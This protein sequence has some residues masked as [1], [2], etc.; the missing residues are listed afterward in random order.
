M[1]WLLALLLPLCLA[2]D[3]TAQLVKN[4]CC[5]VRGW[6]DAGES[7]VWHTTI[8]DSARYNKQS[9]VIRAWPRTLIDSTKARCLFEPWTVALEVDGGNPKQASLS[10]AGDTTFVTA[11][12]T[13][14]GGVIAP[15]ALMSWTS[16]D[17]SIV[18]VEQSTQLVATITAVGAG[19]AFIGG[20]SDGG[21]ADSVQIT[22]VAGCTPTTT[23]L[24]PGDNYQAKITAQANG[25][26]FTFG[27]GSFYGFT[28]TPKTNQTFTGAA[29]HTTILDGG[30]TLGGWTL[31][32]GKW[33]VGNQTQGGSATSNG[34]CESGHP[35]CQ[36]PELLWRD[37]VAQTHESTLAACGAGEWFF[38]YTAD[39]IYVCSDP[40][41]R[42]IETNVTNASAFNPGSAT[43]VTIDGFVV[44][45]YAI[46]DFNDGAIDAGTGWLIQNNW[47][48]ENSFKGIR[49]ECDNVTLQSNKLNKNSQLGLSAAGPGCS[50]DGWID[51]LTAL[52]NRLDTNNTGGWTRGFSAGAMKIVNSRAAVFTGNRAEGN[53]G[54]G[55][56]WDIENHDL[57]ST[58]D[59]SYNNDGSGFFYEIS[60]D[61]TFVNPVS[62]GNGTDP[63][64]ALQNGAGMVISATDGCTVSGGRFVNN[65][66][67]I[68]L[69][70]Q[71]RSGDCGLVNCPT[72]DVSVH[73]NVITQSTGKNGYVGA[74]KSDSL[75]L[76]FNNTFECN[77]V[78][79]TGAANVFYFQ[80]SAKTD[81]QWTTA[82]HDDTGCASITRN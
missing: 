75:H 63:S 38:D 45:H 41:G 22:V 44:R 67:G 33:Y 28:V 14:C 80:E 43:G 50:N 61:C 39:R 79:I 78:T 42:L 5:A 29:N 21:G 64:D 26:A 15:N 71:D 49:V 9:K 18:T 77:T 35:R 60:F 7:R 19:T 46:L 51:G 34:S 53:L 62:E 74:Y 66:H 23:H 58:S 56:W 59:S 57:V 4:P 24:C 11:T 36:Y 81:N 82:G 68:V 72:R 32:S 17:E 6:E 73:D 3:S 47:V 25:T 2:S 65:A 30:R 48:L 70:Q 55:L 54:N 76:Y 1:R 40:N 16:S 27:A 20:T 52:T 8:I 37:S 12:V 69:L 31:S 10:Q 13:H